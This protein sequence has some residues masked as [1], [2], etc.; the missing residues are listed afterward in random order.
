MHAGLGVDAVRVLFGALARLHGVG[1]G[2]AGDFVFVHQL[3]RLLLRSEDDLLGAGVGVG[4]DGIGVLL[5]AA[6]GFLVKGLG[7]GLDLVLE[8]ARLGHR[9]VVDF[10]RV[11]RG[12]VRAHLRL[13]DDALAAREHALRLRDGLGQRDA[14]LADQIR[15]FAGV[16]HAHVLAERNSV[17][18]AERA[19]DR[20][21]HAHGLADALR[22]GL[23][24][25][26]PHGPL[27]LRGRLPLQRRG[28]LLGIALVLHLIIAFH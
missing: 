21:D 23:R 11:V 4:E 14:Q 20:I 13:V 18:V 25:L 24:L 28:N 6:A 15:H 19:L 22:A 17:R 7:L 27:L 16:H 8:L 12:F 3:L 10:V 9:V 5:R 2:A 26:A 1:L